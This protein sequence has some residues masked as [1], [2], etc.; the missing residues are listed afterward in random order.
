LSQAFVL[1]VTFAI[2]LYADINHEIWLSC[3]EQA[4]FPRRILLQK[5]KIPHFI[6]AF[7][8]NS[9]YNREMRNAQ[10]FITSEECQVFCIY[11]YKNNAKIL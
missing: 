9:N 10:L 8:E 7:P 3:R 1:V 5:E 4:T 2:N 6:K 11:F